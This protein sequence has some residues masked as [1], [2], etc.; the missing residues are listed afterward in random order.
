LGLPGNRWVQNNDNRRDLRLWND[1]KYWRQA[2]DFWRDLAASLKDHPA[3]YA[4]NIINEPIPEMKTGLAEHGPAS[5][6][7]PWYEKYRGTSHDL[8]AFYETVITAIRQVDLQTPIMLDAG[9]YAQPVAFVYWPKIG[10]E[11]VLYSFHMYE[12]YQFTN[13]K[14]FRKEQSYVY[15]GTIPYAGEDVHW[16][17]QKIENYL[18]PFCE[19][20]KVQKIPS[21]RLV[22]GEFGCYRRNQGCKEYLTDVIAVLN[23]HGLHWAFYSFREDE[24]DGYDYEI[25]SGGLGAA[26]WQAK[27]AGQNP[28]VPRRDNPLFSVMKM[29][30]SL[31]KAP[32]VS[33]VSI[34]NPKVRELV[35]VLSS[36]EWRDRQ[37]AALAIGEMGI[38]AKAAIPFLIERLDD[39]EWQVRKA[40][41][42]ALT[43]MGTEATPA[44]HPLIAALDDEEWHVRKPA[45][46]ALAAIGPASRPAVS[47]LIKALSDEEWHVRKPAA[48]ALAA[49]GPASKPAIPR[50]IETLKDEEWQVRKPAAL[51]LA[52]IGPD[53]R[54]AIPALKEMLNDP[55]WQVQEAATD[56]LKKIDRQSNASG[57]EP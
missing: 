50:L 47:S 25:G 15:P 28:E 14:N 57:L 51:A 26:Y 33:A 7:A 42:I 34:T 48:E 4:Y 43:S 44:V 52:A 55:E 20:A 37:E 36:D 1:H 22:C 18:S 11:K 54:K 24:W 10:D 17:K 35:E 30:F 56:A 12:P 23:S 46:Q 16:N 40:A 13:H 9:W 39:E 53:A 27:E 5:R 21:N 6:Y 2:A 38:V 32:T 3:V 31:S 29:E 45:A 41:A 8:P 19:W 49:I